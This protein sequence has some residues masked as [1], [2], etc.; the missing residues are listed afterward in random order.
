[1][2]ATVFISCYSSFRNTLELMFW[3][4]RCARTRIPG[5]GPGNPRRMRTGAAASHPD[6]FDAQRCQHGRVVEVAAVDDERLLEPRL[7]G[8]E[9]GALELFPVGDDE[10]GIRTVEHERGL[11]DEA[12]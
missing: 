5:S 11:V 3:P 7:D 12:Q 8:V 9:V 1:M 6:V 2:T 10:Q 4:R